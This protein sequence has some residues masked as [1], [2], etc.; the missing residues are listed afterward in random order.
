MG[1]SAD[2]TGIDEAVDQRLLAHPLFDRLRGLGLPDGHYAVFGSAPLYIRGL[3]E[4]LR[5]LDVVARG[6]AWERAEQVGSRAT[7]PSRR[8]RLRVVHG[9]SGSGAIEIFDRWTSDDWKVD[10]LVATAERVGGIRFVPV[11][12]VLDWKARSARRKD[13]DYLDRNRARLAGAGYL[14]RR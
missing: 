13:V 12:V 4:R 11:D 10:D 9:P 14:P 1:Q 6:P 8:G 5:D 3:V 2:V 7:P